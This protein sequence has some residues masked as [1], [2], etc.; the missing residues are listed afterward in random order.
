MEDERIITLYFDRS[1]SA[2]AETDRKYGRLCFDVANRIL[3]SRPDSEECVS[4]TYLGVWNAI[5]PTRP[6][7]FRAFLIRIT[8]NISLSRLRKNLAQRRN[9]AVELSLDELAGMLP[10]ESISPEMTDGT[11]AE[12]INE[13]LDSIDRDAKN[14]FLRKYW[15]FDTV[16]EICERSGFSESK[17]KSSLLRTREKLRAYLTERGVMI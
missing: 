11:V 6:Q 4:D 2:I 9:A 16:A 3:C 17:V 10:D 14:I 1:E 5:P 7:S 12:M 13:F 8:R 15:F